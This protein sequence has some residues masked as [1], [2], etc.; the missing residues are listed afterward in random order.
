MPKV[1]QD[2]IAEKA[3]VSINT[4]S[5]APNNKPDLSPVAR[6]RVLRITK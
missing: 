4:V 6:E 3:G 1:T 5:R 2:V